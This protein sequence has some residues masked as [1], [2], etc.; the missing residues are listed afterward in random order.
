MKKYLIIGSMMLLFA[1]PAFSQNTDTPL[2][3]VIPEETG[4]PNEAARYLYNRLLCLVAGNATATDDYGTSQFFITAKTLTESKD[5]IGSAPAMYAM[6]LVIT[7]YIADWATDRLYSRMSFKAKGVG[8]SETKAYIDAIK[9][10]NI[11]DPRIKQFLEEG[12]AEIIHYYSSQ[13]AEILQ[14]ARMLAAQR[15]YEKAMF[16]LAA[17]PSS[18]ESLYVQA[19]GILAE[20]YK[21]YVDYTG[22]QNLTKARTIWAATQSREGALEAGALLAEID[23]DAACYKSAVQLVAEIQKQVGQVCEMK[24]YNDAVD[25][26]K[27]RLDIARQIGVAFGNHQQPNTTILH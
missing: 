6:D 15:Q 4:I 27:Q 8:A 22:H 2:R 10:M 17:I 24:V 19:Q 11:N 7:L 3:V 14:N 5:V 12:R 20:V 16:I 13:G 23:P 18:C 9:R 21:K 25:L 26:E 1:Y